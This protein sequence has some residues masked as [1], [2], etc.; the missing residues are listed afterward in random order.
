M[1]LG[2]KSILFGAHQFILH[3]IFVAIAYTRLYG[4][5]FDP[6]IWIAFLVHDWGYWGKSDIDGENGKTHPVLGAEIMHFLFD[7]T[8]FILSIDGHTEVDIQPDK[9]LNFTLY[10]SRYYANKNNELYSKLCYADKLAFCIPPMWL[11]LL[12]VNLTGEI[13]EYM[14][15]AQDVTTFTNHSISNQILWYKSLHTHMQ[16]WILDNNFYKQ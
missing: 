11:Y 12:L 15:N 14:N 3:P 9:W 6:R 16:S 2:T 5:P 13:H 1:K 8:P 4:F 10:H 7:D